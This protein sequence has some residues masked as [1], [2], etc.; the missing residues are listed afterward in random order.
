[1]DDLDRRLV[2]ELEKNPRQSNRT[3][4]KNLGVSEATIRKKIDNL[5]SSGTI[6]LTAIPDL[7]RLGFPV[8]AFILLRVDHAKLN[9]ICEKIRESTK[10]WYVCCCVGY[11]DIFTRGEFSSLAEIAD[12]IKH[13]LSKIHGIQHIETLVE[14]EEI[15]R[16]YSRI[17]CCESPK[18]RN[19]QSPDYKISKIDYLLIKHLQKDA[20][21]SQ[22]Q[23]ASSIGVSE[24]T[25]N[26]RIKELV[27]SN[28]ID[29]TAI[30]NPH[31]IGF[32]IRYILLQTRPDMTGEAISRLEKFPQVDY[33]GL[34][35]GPAQILMG[36]HDTS[37]EY[38]SYFITNELIKIDG[39]I[40]VDIL[41]FLQAIKL[42]YM[43][44]P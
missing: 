40:R 20:R 4:A 44:I 5:T 10:F 2:I 42:N 19:A 25:I 24:T 31:I 12:F 18:K 27:D 8:R 33:I 39:I 16:T 22:K 37:A 32:S 15:K 6:M 34:V 21:A 35:S 11:A 38:I 29:L 30:P 14:Y 36:L 17:G 13:D 23:L 41:N 7:K 3:L 9:E 28:L 1:M 43:W 26:R